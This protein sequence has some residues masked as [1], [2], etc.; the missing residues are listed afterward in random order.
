MSSPTDQELAEMIFFVLVSLYLVLSDS[1][2]FPA[3]LLQ[4]GETLGQASGECFLDTL[5]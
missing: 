5:G 4:F 3:N 1:D 2:F